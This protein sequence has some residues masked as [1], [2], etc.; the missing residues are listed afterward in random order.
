MSCSGAL[1]VDPRDPKEAFG[2]STRSYFLVPR[3]FLSVISP[4]LEKMRVNRQYRLFGIFWNALCI[5]SAGSFHLTQ[6]IVQR[7][8]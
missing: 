6:Y 3:L 7:T 8:R 4:S 2:G 1:L 5:P